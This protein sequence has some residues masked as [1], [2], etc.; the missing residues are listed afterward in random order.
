MT[1]RTAK[2]KWV[3][4]S[5]KGDDY[6][7]A[8]TALARAWAALHRGER[9]PW[10]DAARLEALRREYPRLATRLLA[11]L[12][13][14]ALTTRLTDAW[15]AFHRGDY[16]HAWNEGRALGP[17]GSL[18]AAK[19]AAVYTSYLEEDGK[20]A[21]ALL[22]E[23]VAGV[24]EAAT[25]LPTLANAHYF[26]AYALGRLSQRISIVKALAAGHATRI[27][28]CL[29]RTLQ[30]EPRHADAEIA[31]GLYHAEVVG[32]LGALAARLTYGASA[33]AAVKH[34][35]AALKLD[36]GSAIAHM[37]YGNGLLLLQGDRGQ[38]EAAKLYEKAASCKPRD[39]MQWLD[40]AQ[41]RAELD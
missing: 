2:S 27:R 4:I 10:P 39:A 32:K 35:K 28:L 9:E 18:V 41:A 37:E 38:P 40:V 15:R 6:V 3:Q 19:A 7:F 29:E 30:L 5:Y 17:L 25:L 31:L 12:A 33:E 23:A 1:A 24:T 13:P 11:G 22:S 20:R 14:E 36:P 8:G 34:F 21:E 16:Q 26:Q